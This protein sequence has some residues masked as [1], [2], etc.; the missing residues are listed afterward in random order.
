[1]GIAPLLI[2]SFGLIAE[3]V[4]SGV[5]TE[6][7]AWL[8]TGLSVGFG[9]AAAAVGHIADSH[10]A[11]VAFTVPIASGVLVGVFGLA[12]YRRVARPV[13]ESQPVVVGP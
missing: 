13:V 1:M 11:R 4:P 12:L 3:I 6:G 10:G 5:L 7:L 2:T 9:V 8:N